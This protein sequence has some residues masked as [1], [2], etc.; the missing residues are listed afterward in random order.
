MSDLVLKVTEEQ[1]ECL[2]RLVQRELEKTRVEYRHTDKPSF[3]EVVKHEKRILT[4]LLGKL[5][6]SESPAV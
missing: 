4:E 6:G 3:R 1:H 5:L 2:R